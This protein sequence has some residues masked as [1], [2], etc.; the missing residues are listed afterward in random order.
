MKIQLDEEVI[1]LLKEYSLNS[2]EAK[3]YYV[4]L[5][6]GEATATLIAREA[7]I[8]QQRVYDA[9][10][11]L[12]RKGFVQVKNTNPKRYIPIPPR[13]ALNNRIRQLRLEFEIREDNLKK[14]VDKIEEKIPEAKN[15]SFDNG[16]QVFILE[17]RESI[18]NQAISMI[19]SARST[20]KIAGIKPLFTLGCKG[21]LKKYLKRKVKI[22]AM[23][24]F[25]KPCKEEIKKLGGEYCEAAACCQYLLIVD[26][27]K[28]LIVYFDEKGAPN[29][30]YTE[31]EAIIKP[32][33][34]FFDQQWKN[35]PS[36][37]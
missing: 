4:L 1:K 29:G 8:P 20:V 3:A 12:E 2:Y 7:Q 5:L 25:D 21:N 31:N 32:F 19:S 15:S 26:D 34:L 37:D 13:K 6:L 16:F 10:R 28:L 27:S 22:L 18:V 11:S 9:L 14:L 17:G 24:E 36:K 35:C 30:L 33:I 23:G